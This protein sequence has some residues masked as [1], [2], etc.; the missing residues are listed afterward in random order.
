MYC[1]GERVAL[2]VPVSGDG[3]L[4]LAACRRIVMRPLVMPRPNCCMGM[5]CI[6]GVGAV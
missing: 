2:G 4:M 1:C 6:D 5:V 3:L